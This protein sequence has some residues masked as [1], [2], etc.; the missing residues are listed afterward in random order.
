MDNWKSIETAPKDGTKILLCSGTNW[1]EIEIGYWV[2]VGYNGVKG[3]WTTGFHCA[4]EGDFD[5]FNPTHW[6]PLP[7]CPT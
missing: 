7:E 6:M 1:K 5:I 2:V 4:D 3:K